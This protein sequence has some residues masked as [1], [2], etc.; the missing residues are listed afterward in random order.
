VFRKPGGRPAFTL[1]ELLVVIAII[2][3]LIALLLPAVQK[4]REAANRTQC[5]NNLK[6]MGIAIH[7]YHNTHNLLPP[8]GYHGSGEMSWAVQLLPYL[9]QDNAYKEWDVTAIG[10][11]FRL[12]A[13]PAQEAARQLQVK[14][15]YCPSRRGP[16]QLSKS[17]HIRTNFNGIT[18][19]PIPGSLGDYASVGGGNDGT[20]TEQGLLKALDQTGTWDLSRGVYRIIQAVSRTSFTSCPDGLSNTAVIGEK[21]VRPNWFGEQNRLQAGDG[22]FFSDNAPW[23]ITRLMGRHIVSGVTI[24]L[25]LANDANDSLR[26]ADRFGSYH[27]GI[28][29]FVFGDGSVR[30]LPNS[31]DVIVLTRLA[32]PDDGETVTL[33]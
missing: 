7:N 25:M 26:P 18:T 21:H 17:G 20:L 32:L 16:P 19:Y 3:V 22:P 24:D 27:P 12:G 30:V 14:T 28:C 33:P 29:Q 4:V 13:T 2:G 5:G 23:N 10:A 8:M 15:Y 11:F 31:T 6:Q 9:E 1:I